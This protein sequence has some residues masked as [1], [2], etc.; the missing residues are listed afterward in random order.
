MNN[1]KDTNSIKDISSA[2]YNLPIFK[3]EGFSYLS[4]KT[5]RIATAMYMITNFMSSS[6]PLKW[7][8]RDISLKMLDSVMSLSNTSLSNRDILMREISGKL[9]H[10]KTLFS[11]AHRSGFISVMNY[12]I[13]D[14][15]LNK[16]AEYVIDYDRDKLSMN[17][18][19]FGEGFWESDNVPQQKDINQKDIGSKDYAQKDKINNTNIARTYSKNY[20]FKLKDIKPSQVGREISRQSKEL[21]INERRERIIKILKDKK[22]VSVKDIST[23][24]TDCS[25]KTLQR[26]LTVMLNDRIIK[27]SG[28][29]RWSKYSLNI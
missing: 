26:E 4:S 21:K 17:A 2:A 10:I 14:G 25:E 13:I 19:L 23:Q 6:E 28:D 16:L 27:K 11:V 8:I 24:I 1:K 3:D 18:E 20:S 29:R 22:E 12:E 7:Q 9:F 15:E 5:E